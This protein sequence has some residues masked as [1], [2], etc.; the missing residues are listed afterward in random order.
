MKL[1][2]WNQVN[3]RTSV[4]D[5]LPKEIRDQLIEA[6]TAGTHSTS[7]MIA[8]LHSEGYTDVSLN[9]LTWY[10]RTRNITI[11]AKRDKP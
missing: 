4:V 11:G 6:R 1:S 8:W 7:S 5:R 2:D 9:S 3:T 10:F